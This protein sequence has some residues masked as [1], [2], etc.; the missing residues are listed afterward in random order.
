MFSKLNDFRHK[1]TQKFLD[2]HKIAKQR[3]KEK[4]A[5][6]RA[7][8]DLESE[9]LE[10]DR[11]LQPHSEEAV[12]KYAQGMNSQKSVEEIEA[13]M[14]RTLSEAELRRGSGSIRGVKIF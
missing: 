14:L 13:S 5:K 7:T 3:V 4:R 8:L 6:E 12:S 11:A 10:E 9:P 1:Q 2:G